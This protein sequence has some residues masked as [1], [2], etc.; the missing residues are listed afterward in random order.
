MEVFTVKQRHAPSTTPLSERLKTYGIE[1]AESPPRTPQS[2]T[3]KKYWG[4]AA[5]FVLSL[6]LITTDV[7]GANQGLPTITKPWLRLESEIAQSKTDGKNKFLAFVNKEGTHLRVLNLINGDS[8]L[9]TENYVG[10]SFFWAPDHSRLIFTSSFQSKDGPVT[11]LAAFDLGNKKVVEMDQ[12][13]SET[14]SVSFD[15]RDN[16]FF[17]VHK[18]GVLSKTIKMP[19]S[20]LAKWQSRK[21]PKIGRYLATPQ[22]MTFMKE[23]GLEISKLEDDKTGVESFEISTDGTA[24]AWATQSG[25]IYVS[26]QGEKPVFLDFGRDPKWHPQKRILLYAGA[27]KI[28][29]K[30]SGYDLK[31]AEIDGKKSWLTADSYANQRWPVWLPSQN[32]ILFTKGSTTDLYLM[33]YV[34]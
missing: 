29:Q 3:S 7:F 4:L 12:L 33:D 26:E 1:T 8:F 18:K 9:V 11:L 17:L 22:S 25:S 32:K 19:E 5:G 28:G 30:T 23:T 31:I 6:N 24:V 16:K 20:R 13:N 14:G 15:P 2:V 34:P 27:H 21:E 10:S